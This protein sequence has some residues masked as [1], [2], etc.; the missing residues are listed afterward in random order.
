MTHLI[1]KVTFSVKKK[2]FAHFTRVK[3]STR[4]A[5]AAITS[6]TTNGTRAKTAIKY[7]MASSSL[8]LNGSYFC[9]RFVRKIEYSSVHTFPTV[10]KSIKFLTNAEKLSQ[11]EY[12]TPPLLNYQKKNSRSHTAAELIYCAKSMEFFAHKKY[13]QRF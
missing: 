9:R 5:A 1:N 3:I 10:S 7:F 6:K 13:S 8:L 11:I 4:A 12:L 2:R